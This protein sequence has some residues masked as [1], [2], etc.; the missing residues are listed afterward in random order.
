VVEHHD[1]WR[2]E[3]PFRRYAELL[4][5]NQDLEMVAQTHL[6]HWLRAVGLVDD[7]A[8]ALVISSGGS[9]E[10]VLVAAQ[11][12]GEQADWGTA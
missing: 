3:H 4:Q 11:P 6:E 10:P 8:T 5:T 7:G 1:Q 12:E 2:R 9:I